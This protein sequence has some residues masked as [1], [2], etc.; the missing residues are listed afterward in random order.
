MI[1]KKVPSHVD[2]A[3]QTSLP[4]KK[5]KFKTDILHILVFFKFTGFIIC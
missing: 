5:D 1:Y 2:T 4:G 3:L